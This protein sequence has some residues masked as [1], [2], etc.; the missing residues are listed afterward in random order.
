M[1][2]Y[3]GFTKKELITMLAK[4]KVKLIKKDMEN[5]GQ[6]WEFVDG[7]QTTNTIEKTWEN[8]YKTYP[9]TSKSTPMFSLSKLYDEM[10]ENK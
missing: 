5:K 6:Q 3:K 1:K 4:E 8:L 7:F 10:I 2:K 9:I